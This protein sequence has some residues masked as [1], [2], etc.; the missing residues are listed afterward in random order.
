MEKFICRSG[1]IG[2][3]AGFKIQFGLSQVPVR[4]RPSVQRETFMFPFYFFKILNTKYFVYAIKS[5]VRADIYIGMTNN[6]K[7]RI[8]DHNK[9]YNRTIKAYT[10]FKLIYTEAFPS[11]LKQGKKKNILNLEYVKNS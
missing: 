5:K 2:R 1:G 9:G 3:R 10:P 7:I 6:L 8:S 11:R 4:A